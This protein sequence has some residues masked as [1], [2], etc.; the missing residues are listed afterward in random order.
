M[1]LTSWGKPKK[2][3]CRLVDPHYYFFACL[4]FFSFPFSLLLIK[5]IPLPSDTYYANIWAI[6]SNKMLILLRCQSVFPTAVDW[7]ILEFGSIW[8]ISDGM[9]N[10]AM[11]GFCREHF[12]M[13]IKSFQALSHILSLIYFWLSLPSSSLPIADCVTIEL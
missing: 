7:I 8:E 1:N 6:L 13:N 9:R 12:Q 11:C 4:S 2:I 3:N 5:V 10:P